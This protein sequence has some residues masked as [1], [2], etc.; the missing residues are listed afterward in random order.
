MLQPTEALDPIHLSNGRVLSSAR[1]IAGEDRRG[2]RIPNKPVRSVRRS[3]GHRRLAMLPQNGLP[4][5][6][7]WTNREGCSRV[8]PLLAWQPRRRRLRDVC[9]RLTSEGLHM[10]SWFVPPIVV[11]IGFVILAMG[12]ALYRAY[13]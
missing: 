13:S 2:G 9:S 6:I 4:A 11:P 5:P 1:L 8:W 7:R 12:Y 10:A 3:D